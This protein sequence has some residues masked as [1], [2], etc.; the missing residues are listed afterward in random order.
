MALALVGQVQFL[1][2]L[3]LVDT[4]GAE[5]SYVL[6]FAENLRWVNLWP[7][8]DVVEIFTPLG[9]ARRL[10][11][12]DGSSASRCDIAESE[13]GGLG[14]TVFVGNLVLFAGI[15]LTIFVLHVLIASGVEAYWL[16][17]KHAKERIEMA[18]LDGT[19]IRE[20]STSRLGERTDRS[21]AGVD[22]TAGANSSGSNRSQRWPFVGG[23]TLRR[24]GRDWEESDDDQ[25]KGG[26]KRGQSVT[27]DES[28]LNPLSVCR[29]RSQA[30]WL[31]FP[32][33][34]LLFLFFAFEGAVATE[35]AVLRDSRCPWVIIV[36]ATA[37]ILYPV[38]MFVMVCRTI[39]VRVLPDALIVFETT[40]DSIDPEDGHGDD[41][42]DQ[43]P[44]LYS[45]VKNGL[46]EDGSFFSWADTGQWVTAE[47]GNQE[48]KREGDSFRIGFE[49][50]FV[51]F[52]KTG[53]WFMAFSLL[54]SAAMASIGVLVDERVPKLLLFGGVHASCCMIL[55]RFRPFSN[56]LINFAG[57]CVAGAD[58]VSMAVLA[59][60]AL[61]W[62][63]TENAKRADAA[64]M[65]IQLLVLAAL[66]VPMYLDTSAVIIAKVRSVMCKRCSGS[67]REERRFIRRYIRGA[68]AST[69]CSMLGKNMFA[70]IEDTSAGVRRPPASVGDPPPARMKTPGRVTAAPSGPYLSSGGCPDKSEGPRRPGTLGTHHTPIAVPQTPPD[71]LTGI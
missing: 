46:I 5:A 51:D 11:E 71:L 44:S 18:H 30:A 39:I 7:P 68:W 32:H 65:I 58:A 17:K 9:T 27:R 53:S 67:R 29:D 15:L 63:G 16:T 70:C 57:V 69:W 1:A 22:S 66:I 2:T 59:A 3:S 14:A 56:R 38:L 52:T 36:S 21:G 24:R 35:V 55:V 25:E 20:L 34:E 64:V 60:A 40:T 37:L 42:P 50:I 8:E 45:R 4:T 49:P 13:S 48:A 54:Q 41:D 12:T 6:D 61:A 28:R 23:G 26:Q 43:Q 19:P 10:Q 62:D 31:H 33:I 47:R